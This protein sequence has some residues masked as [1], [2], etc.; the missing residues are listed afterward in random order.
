MTCK[1][2]QTLCPVVCRGGQDRAAAATR[3]LRMP[4]SRRGSGCRLGKLGSKQPRRRC[5]KSRRRLA[6]PSKRVSRTWTR[7]SFRKVCPD[8]PGRDNA[9]QFWEHSSI[10]TVPATTSSTGSPETSQDCESSCCGCTRLAGAQSPSPSSPT[11]PHLGPGSSQ[12][13]P[14]RRHWDAGIYQP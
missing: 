4:R 12:E 13:R 14:A 2:L 7:V 8:L 6:Q 3:W 1:G 11:F 5:Q 10:V 9:G